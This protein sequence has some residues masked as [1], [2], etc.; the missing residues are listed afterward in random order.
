MKKE[1][2]QKFISL[3]KQ[4]AGEKGGFIL[5]GMFRR[6]ESLT[7]D[8]VISSFWIGNDTGEPLKYIVS[9]IKSE[10]NQDEMTT[11]SGIILL[12][13]SNEFV[14]AVNEEFDTEHKIVKCGRE[15]FNGISVE[16]GYIITS[17]RTA[18]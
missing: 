16:K 18:D 8:V 1:L 5:F 7:W 2:V 15:D 9:K 12:E 13:P 4:L 11:L 17:K 6:E 3:E 14:K 10:L